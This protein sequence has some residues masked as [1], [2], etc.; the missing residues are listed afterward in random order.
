MSP[1]YLATFEKMLVIETIGGVKYISEDQ[2]ARAFKLT[3][4]E[5]RVLFVKEQDRKGLKRR[6]GGLFATA[7]GFSNLSLSIEGREEEKAI[8]IKCLGGVS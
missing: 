2:V 5:A 3:K 7:Y 6:D 4:A 8:V 1:S